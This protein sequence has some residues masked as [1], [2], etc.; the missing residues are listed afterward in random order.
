MLLDTNSSNR[1]NYLL[2]LLILFVTI[3]GINCAV[4]TAGQLLEKKGGQK[5]KQQINSLKRNSALN[6]S[7]NS[8]QISKEKQKQNLK[9]LKN[10]VVTKK[11]ISKELQKQITK[12][13]QKELKELKEM[14][15]MKA[16][17]KANLERELNEKIQNGIV[18]NNKIKKHHHKNEK[19]K[20]NIKNK[21]IL[22]S[23]EDDE[24]VIPTF[25][26]HPGFMPIVMHKLT[27]Y[28][29]KSSELISK[30]L[31]SA[32][33]VRNLLWTAVAV[34]ERKLVDN[35]KGVKIVDK[36]TQTCLLEFIARMVGGLIHLLLSLRK[37]LTITATLPHLF[38]H[39]AKMI[40]PSFRL[41]IANFGVKKLPKKN[42]RS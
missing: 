27:E 40:S 16:I 23:D 9:N 1:K 5:Q 8:K 29:I 12:K 17:M 22:D 34:A 10:N 26:E 39:Y 36:G 2:K 38:T 21:E 41:D 20:K 19:N 3:C 35:R 4:I 15:A 31:E 32:K 33:D 28:K 7:K 13:Q 6:I 24:L 14:E 37:T 25:G 30:R 18:E 11:V 42:L